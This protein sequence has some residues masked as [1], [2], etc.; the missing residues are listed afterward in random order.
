MDLGLDID[1][2]KR[3]IDELVRRLPAHSVP[4]A[5]LQEMEDLEEMLALAQAQ[6]EKM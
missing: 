6:Q 3:R 1:R 2:L 4:P 5:M